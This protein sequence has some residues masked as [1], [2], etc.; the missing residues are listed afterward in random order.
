MI[1]MTLPGSYIRNITVDGDVMQPYFPQTDCSDVAINSAGLNLQFVTE[2]NFRYNLNQALFRQDGEDCVCRVVFAFNATSD[3]II[4]G[5]PSQYNFNITVD[6]DNNL[7]GLSG[8]INLT[9]V[10][11]DF[12]GR[13]TIL[14][15]VFSILTFL[16]LVINFTLDRAR[17][18]L[19]AAAEAAGKG[20][21]VEESE[22]TL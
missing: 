21:K 10:P 6:F 19:E 8:G 13:V 14:V 4:L 5:Q 3:L 7:I 1:G 20:G 9:P 15:V 2:K 22:K 18:E 12:K 11:V 17:K 16:G